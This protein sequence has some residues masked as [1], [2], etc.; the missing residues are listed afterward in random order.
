MTPAKIQKYSNKPKIT[1]KHVWIWKNWKKLDWAHSNKHWKSLEV[2]RFLWTNGNKA[3]LIGKKNNL[4]NFFFAKIFHFSKNVFKNHA[5][6]LTKT[7]LR[8]SV[9]QLIFLLSRNLSKNN[10]N[11]DIFSGRNLFTNSEKM[12]TVQICFL[13]FPLELI[14]WTQPGEQLDLINPD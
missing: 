9:F 12:D 8:L 14:W 2:G 7:K 13:T 3:H 5:F 4:L 1:T 6:L 10:K 11:F